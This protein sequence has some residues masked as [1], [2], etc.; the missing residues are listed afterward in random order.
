MIESF[1]EMM[2]GERASSHNTISAYRRDLEACS[3]FLGGE[4]R[5][6]KAEVK[7]IQ[8][9]LISLAKEGLSPQTQARRLSSLKQYYRFLMSEAVREDNPTLTLDAPKLGRPLP[10]YLSEAQVSDLLT[11]AEA[12]KDKPNGLRLHCMIEL[13]YATGLRVSELVNLPL[14]AYR[15]G[16]GFLRIKGKGGKERIAPLSA[17]AIAAIEAWLILRDA[18]LQQ[19]M[20]RAKYLNQTLWM[21]PGRGTDDQGKNLGHISRWRFAQLLKDLALIAGLDPEKIS[22]HV[23]RHAFASHLLANGANLR[24]VQ[25]MLG[26]SDISTTQIYTHILDKQMQE[27]VTKHHPLS[28]K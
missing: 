22:P 12:N 10:K 2:A 16:Q 11:C 19:D 13:L 6:E 14:A 7:A 3:L 24:A 21:F 27:L 17:R 25:Q 9:Y 26:H 23:I 4:K 15:K 18:E 20:V 8:S 28:K 1:L 5:L